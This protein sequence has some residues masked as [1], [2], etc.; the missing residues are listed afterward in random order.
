MLKCWPVM[1][2]T[3]WAT[4]RKQ[5]LTNV[6]QETMAGGSI[7]SSCSESFSGEHKA[8]A[9]KGTLGLIGVLRSGA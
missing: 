8:V 5:G 2:K 7:L 4:Q 9:L 1:T 6:F 3:K